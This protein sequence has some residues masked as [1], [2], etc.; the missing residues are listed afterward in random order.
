MTSNWIASYKWFRIKHSFLCLAQLH[1]ISFD[2]SACQVHYIA[3]F[4][5]VWLTFLIA[6]GL[7]HI[8]P[9]LHS[10]FCHHKDSFVKLHHKLHLIAFLM[11]HNLPEKQVI[12]YEQL[13]NN[14]KICT[15]NPWHP[16]YISKMGGFNSNFRNHKLARCKDAREAQNFQISQWGVSALE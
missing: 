7:F 11:H 8:L 5:A 10:C 1:I 14:W 16:F 6:L 13:N 2:I 9:K 15:G 12:G 3:T 4:F